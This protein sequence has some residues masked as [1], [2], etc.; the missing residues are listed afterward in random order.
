MVEEIHKAE[1]QAMILIL[2]NTAANLV[3]YETLEKVGTRKRHRLCMLALTEIRTRFFFMIK[4]EQV[5]DGVLKALDDWKIEL[6]KD[7]ERLAFMLKY[8]I[9]KVDFTLNQ[10]R[11]VVSLIGFINQVQSNPQ[12]AFKEFE[13]FKKVTDAFADDPDLKLVEESFQRYTYGETKSKTFVKI[14]TSLSPE[15]LIYG[16][17]TQNQIVIEPVDDFVYSCFQFHVNYLGKPPKGNFQF[18]PR[19]KHAFTVLLFEMKRRKWITSTK[20]EITDLIVQLIPGSSRASL[21]K[22]SSP[23]KEISSKHAIDPQLFK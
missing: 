14:K 15:K 2:G 22:Y 23:S 11:F 17:S 5:N 4:P 9:P 8:M 18:T 21:K 20:E 3:N 12:N 19:F 1:S 13:E 10:K 7:D 6:N 16:F